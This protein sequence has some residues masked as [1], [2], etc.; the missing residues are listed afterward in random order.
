MPRLTIA[1]LET[2]YDHLADALDGAPQGQR[3][4]LLVKLA[5]LAA[6][7]LGDAARFAEL[8]EA[9]RRDL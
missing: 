4:L 1:E 8:T 5:L 3:E 7:E 6:E 2:L 9:A